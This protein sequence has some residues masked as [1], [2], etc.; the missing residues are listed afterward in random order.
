MFCLWP[1]RL[2]RSL[3]TRKRSMDAGSRFSSYGVLPALRRLGGYFD[4]TNISQNG[5]MKT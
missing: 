5:Y 1:T 3:T 2:P 4:S